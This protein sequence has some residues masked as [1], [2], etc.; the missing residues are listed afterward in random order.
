VKSTIENDIEDILNFPKLQN[1]NEDHL[2]INLH[3]CSM[4]QNSIT[5]DVD[6]ITF[7]KNGKRKI[8]EEIEDLSK[9]YVLSAYQYRLFKK[10][11]IKLANNISPSPVRK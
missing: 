6:L 5:I 9:V 1:S 4:C 11:K 3:R 10:K 7:N 2:R 8:E